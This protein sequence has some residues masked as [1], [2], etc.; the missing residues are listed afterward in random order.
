LEKILKT[1]GVSYY[2]KKDEMKPELLKIGF[3]AQEL[4]MVFPNM[5]VENKSPD[6]ENSVLAINYD[7]I[8]SACIEAI[9]EQSLL[10]DYHEIELEKLEDIAKNKGIL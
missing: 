4:Q 6:G 3:I 1:R 7:T 9:K 8:I 2:L 5:V 10:L